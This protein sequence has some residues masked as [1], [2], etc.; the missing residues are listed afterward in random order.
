MRRI[1][2]IRDPF[3]A[4]NDWVAMSPKDYRLMR[5][6][7]RAAELNYKLMTGA[8]KSKNSLAHITP[9]LEDALDAFNA[10][11]KGRK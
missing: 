7:V 8:I 6:V 5:A 10:K 3:V 9:E 2:T 1:K 11:G 4:P